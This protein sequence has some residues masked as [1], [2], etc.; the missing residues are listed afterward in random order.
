MKELEEAKKILDIEIV[1][2][3][4]HKIMRVSQSGYVSKILNNFRIDNGKSVKMPLGGHS[5]LSLKDRSVMDCNV[6]RMNKVLYENAIGSLMYLM[7]CTRPDI[8]YAVSV[9]S[10]YL[11]KPDRGNHV[12]VTSFV[13]SDYAKD[14]DKGRGR[15]YG[16]DGGYEGS[17]LA[18]GSLRR[19]DNQ[20]PQILE[21][22]KHMLLPQYN[23]DALVDGKEHDDDIQKSVSPDIHSSSSGAQT[24]KQGDKTEN[25]D[26]G[27]S[28]VAGFKDLNTEFEECTNNSND[29]GAGADINN[30]EFIISV[31]P[32]PT[33]RI[34]KTHL[35][36]QIIG[37][38]S[39]TTQTRTMELML[40]WTSRKKHAKCLMLLVKDL[41]LSSQDDVV[42]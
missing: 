9:V 8:A 25:K 27:K 11:A 39:S 31:S 2:D 18:K 29:V 33:T 19:V 36:S 16:P 38:L 22:D 26:K 23:K 12:D 15:V 4:S 35:T 14:P 17:H 1:R 5:K 21:V 3:Q 32:I 34:H 30:L 28:P 40:L 37:D 42:E 41:V 6:E 7:V 24:R 10:R 20:G 13:D